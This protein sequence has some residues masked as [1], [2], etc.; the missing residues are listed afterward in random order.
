MMNYDQSQIQ[1]F[2]DAALDRLP[3]AEVFHES[4]IPLKKHGKDYVALCPFHSEKTPSCHIYTEQN[5]YYCF[6]CA[7]NG[8]ALHFLMR[9]ENLSFL[10]A[11]KQLS[12]KSGIPLPERKKTGGFG[13][14]NI[15]YV[16]N[17]KSVEKTK[18][19]FS[20]KK[21]YTPIIHDDIDI[22]NCQKIV[23]MAADIYHK[24]INDERA[25]DY[26]QK[27]KITKKSV[28]TFYI[29]Y[30]DWN[31][32]IHDELRLSK[33]SDEQM[34]KAGVIIFKSD[35]K[36]FSDK[37]HNRLIFPI[38]D[39]QGHF[40]GMG[41]RYIDTEIKHGGFGR[42]NLPF[43]AKY[44]NT[45]E[46]AAYHKSQILYGLY[47][48]KENI[49]KTKKAFVVEGY[50]DVIGLHQCDVKNAVASCGT[51]FTEA[52]MT[53]LLQ[54]A[55]EVTFCF[56]GD[57]A[58][59]KAALKS[60]EK[61]LPFLQDNVTLR[62]MI[63]PDGQDPQDLS[64]DNDGQKTFHRLASQ[65]VSALDFLL[66]NLKLQNP[67]ST[68]EEAEQAVITASF[69]AEQITGPVHRSAWLS[70]VQSWIKPWISQAFP[71]YIAEQPE[72]KKINENSSLNDL[73]D[74]RITHKDYQKEISP[75]SESL[76]ERA[77]WMLFYLEWEA[78]QDLWHN[79]PLQELIYDAKKSP[80][81]H[82]I[83]QT[84]QSVFRPSQKH[85][86]EMARYL[87]LGARQSIYSVER[88]Q[89]VF[90]KAFHEMSS[91]E[92]RQELE[93]II[94]KITDHARQSRKIFLAI[95]ESIFE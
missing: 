38:R 31:N 2:I 66:E 61:M 54:Y 10:E 36:T 47:E 27:R 22:K 88:K 94:N 44:I 15:P 28:D 60:V 39:V 64:S 1:A 58:G 18:K 20:V 92:K 72:D 26:L 73:S 89:S 21:E 86:I 23:K 65:S 33:V 63:L 85:P 11:L 46:T 71:M 75:L 32:V 87:T 80:A 93:G 81:T 95:E 43:R 74:D 24:K 67:V 34:E 41:G 62:V 84:L 57:D 25:M 9:H 40:C 56:D 70:I 83:Y 3:I 29:G 7:A 69:Y 51:A 35:E 59:K 13:S 42:S 78:Y 77:V 48:N 5:R 76:L 68:K 50:L 79:I 16:F 49:Q 17:G 8:N 91:A 52:Q 45:P 82:Q 55:Q 19:R 14:Q 53:E 6:G 30:A 37:F 90:V 12:H 4:G